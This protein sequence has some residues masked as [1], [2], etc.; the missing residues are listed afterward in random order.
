[1]DVPVKRPIGEWY[2]GRDAQLDAAVAELLGRIG[3]VAGR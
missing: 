3:K 1:V 2:S